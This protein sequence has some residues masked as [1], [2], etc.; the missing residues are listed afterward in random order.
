VA[1]PCAD[2][3]RRSAASVR[4]GSGGA[5]VTLLSSQPAP[6]V[7]ASVWTLD[8]RRAGIPIA[9]AEVHVVGHAPKRPGE[10]PLEATVTALGAGRYEVWPVTFTAPGHDPAPV[11][12]AP[13]GERGCAP[14]ESASQARRGPGPHGQHRHGRPQQAAQRRSRER[15]RRV[16]HVA[17]GR[18]GPPHDARV[19]PIEAGRFER[20]RRR[21]R[22]ARCRGAKTLRQ[23]CPSPPRACERRSRWSPERVLVPLRWS[24]S[25][26]GRVGTCVATVSG[27]TT[28]YRYF[29]PKFTTDKAQTNCRRI[30]GATAFTP[31]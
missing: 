1:D 30:P 16:A 22:R 9:D 5:R 6:F 31:N 21:S 14:E 10:T 19:R 20:H 8:V 23:A 15:R 28:A 26:A 2:L 25:T 29:E 4:V 17:R 7:G 12:R 18:K 3:V 27:V 11:E 24:R 13:L